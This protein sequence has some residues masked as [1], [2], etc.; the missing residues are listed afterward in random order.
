MAHPKFDFSDLTP[1][2]RIQ[3]AEDLWDSL[4]ADASTV[5][6]TAPQARELDRRLEAYRRDGDPGQP[7]EAVL[8]RVEERLRER[9]G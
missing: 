9:G 7:W 3:L 6:L 4:S 8:D 5:P 2:E 1:D